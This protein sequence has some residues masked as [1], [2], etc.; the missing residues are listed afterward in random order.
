[1]LSTPRKSN[2][3]TKFAL[4]GRSAAHEGWFEKPSL[5]LSTPQAEVGLFQDKTNF[6]EKGG[7][8]A[9]DAAFEKGMEAWLKGPS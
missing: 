2:G 5:R 8:G 3:A 4:R 1:M 9:M 7:I 6:L